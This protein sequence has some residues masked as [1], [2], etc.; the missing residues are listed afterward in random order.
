MTRPPRPA[1][2]VAGFLAVT[3]VLLVPLLA[4]DENFPANPTGS[5]AAEL[6]A[7]GGGGRCGTTWGPAREIGRIPGQRKEVSG[8]V[9]SPRYPGVAW[10]VRDS[11]NP[12]VLYSFELPPGEHAIRSRA[13]PVRGATNG[14]WEDVAYTT[15]PDGRGHLW[16]SDN[17]NRHTAPKM[18]WEVLEPDPD[19]DREA[20]VVAHYR[21]A[22]PDAPDGNHDTETAFFLGGKLTI[23]S[24]TE[25]SRAYRF[26]APLDPNTVNRP[27]LVATVPAGVK[28]VLGS[29]SPDERLLVM[30][31]T[32]DQTAWVYA[33][34]HDP[35]DVAGFFDRPPLFTRELSRSQ[36]EAGDFFPYDGCDIVL[37][38]ERQNVWLMSNR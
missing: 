38:S 19:R 16:I 12:A 35:P 21:W 18:L 4:G 8:F 27:T 33:N 20:T 37:L 29:T 14:D 3:V 13:F 28:M 1:V 22:Y 15:G 23:V 5:A 10:M 26:D 17:V 25:P 7:A 36:R 30:S 11:G 34:E 6:P 31:S 32:H 24:K 9:S 2:V